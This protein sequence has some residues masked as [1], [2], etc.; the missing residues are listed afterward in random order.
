MAYAKLATLPP[1]YGLYSAFMGTFIYW[2]FATSK[3]I[4]IGVSFDTFVSRCALSTNL[5]QPVAVMSTVVGTVILDTQHAHPKE[6]ISGP[7][8]ASAMAIIAG[9]I[10][11][12]LGL[13]R[14]GWFVEFI[15]LASI[16]AFITGSAFNIAIGQV[17][18]LMGISSKYVDSRAST[19]QVVINTLKNLGHTK[20]DAALGLTC[21]LFLYIIKYSLAYSAK[22][23]PS[24]ARW[25]FFA[26]TLRT[27]F[28]ILLYTLIS[29]LVNRHH[30]KNPKFGI[31]STVPRGRCQVWILVHPLRLTWLCRL[32]SCR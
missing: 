26:N 14:L 11:A 30:R 24:R 22:K 5:H 12:F 19:Y 10:V 4:T 7:V 16:C 31:L 20:L 28:V 1:Q 17:P 2:F 13:V 3:D 27:V 29:W 18:S 23:F 9:A 6:Q 32:Q 21:L 8:I 15:P 25:I